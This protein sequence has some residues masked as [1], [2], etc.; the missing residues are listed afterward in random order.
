MAVMIIVLQSCDYWSFGVMIYAMIC[1]EWPFTIRHNAK[2][3]R[4]FRHTCMLPL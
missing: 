2:Y 3:E 1:G 4:R